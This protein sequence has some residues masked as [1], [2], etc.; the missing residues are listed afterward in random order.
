M[1]DPKKHH[2]LPVFYLM[3][4]TSANGKLVEFS[5]PFDEEVKPRRTHPSG[6][7]YIDKLYA[8]EG[9]PGEISYAV[10]KAFLSPV[11]SKAATALKELMSGRV[12]SSQVRAAWSHFIMTLLMRMPV[13]IQIIKEIVKKIETTASDSLLNFVIRHSPSEFHAEAKKA[14][15]EI[16]SSII[17]RSIDHITKIM[18]AKDIVDRISNMEWDVIDLSASPHELLTSDR[19]ILVEKNDKMSGHTVIALP[20]APSKIFVAATNHSLVNE[21]RNTNPKKIVH[22]ANKDI[23]SRANR[24]VYGK[25]DSQLPFIR[26]HFGRDRSPSFIEDNAL[27]TSQ[28]AD[29]IALHFSSIY[30]SEMKKTFEDAL[31]IRRMQNVTSL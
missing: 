29:D 1:N 5:T 28:S 27:K 30:D 7:G 8:I 4:W 11:D 12:A 31:K 22:A 18:S 10:E 24:L 14:F 25:T 13:E 15:D 3:S 26:K 9:L 17:S 23:V 6:T 20:I 16:K 2:F 19:P 21:L